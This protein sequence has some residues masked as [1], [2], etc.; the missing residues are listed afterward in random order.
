MAVLIGESYT[1]ASDYVPGVPRTIQ[2]YGS[3]AR[4]KIMNNFKI[5]MHELGYKIVCL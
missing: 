3:F 2:I 1:P 4:V 5:V